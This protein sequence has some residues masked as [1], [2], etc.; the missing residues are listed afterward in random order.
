MKMLNRLKSTAIILKNHKLKFA[1]LLIIFSITF[2]ALPLAAPFMIQFII[3]RIE[4]GMSVT[5]LMIFLIIMAA[6]LMLT[7]DYMINVYGNVL[8]AN[9]IYRG[10]ADLYKD[11]FALPY[12]EREAKYKDE[13][14]LQN[15]TAFTDSALSLWVMIIRCVI[16]VIVIGVLLILSIH[17]HF[18]AS[19]FILAH[20][21]ITVIAG[22]KIHG[23]SETYASQLQ[24]FEAVKNENIEELMYKADFI[25]MNNLQN[26]IKS[27]FDQ[28]RKDIF[29]VQ[30]EQ[31]KKNN[32][33]ISLQKVISELVSGFIYPVLGFLPGSVKIAGGNLASVKSIMEESGNQ[34]QNIQEMAAYIPYNTVPIDNG[35]ELFSLTRECISSR[36]EGHSREKRHSREEI[37]SQKSQNY[38]SNC[39][40]AIH[41]LCFETEGR[42]ILSDI[43]LSIKEGEHIAVMGENGS[44]KSTLLRCIMGMYSPTSGSITLFGKSPADDTEYF[45]E[46]GIF[47]YMP[48][49]SQLYETTIDENISMGSFSEINLEKIKNAT[50]VSDFSD[51]EISSVSQ[52]SGGEQQ[53]VNAARALSNSNAKLILLDEPT[54]SLDRE[55]AERLMNYIRSSKATVI[56]TT[57]REEEAAFADR[58]IQMCNGKEV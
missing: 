1:A 26:I 43:N 51:R 4:S 24:G 40:L 32:L 7:L 30:T 58:V 20:I 15:I 10:S 41:R 3:G 6:F 2:F 38:G 11:L 35:R 39:A 56:Y 52:L 21:G 23:I 27:R 37:H 47:S 44:G 31:L 13:D 19:F 36:E 12:G 34:A 42:I 45:R 29:H 14:L 22:K 16:S 5:P 28:T 48:S 53:R 8:C 9:L 17:V 55:H 46:N 18:T 49:A 50:G 57:H 54:A 33:Y 25:N